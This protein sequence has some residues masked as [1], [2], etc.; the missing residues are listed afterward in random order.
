MLP[1]GTF[2]KDFYKKMKNLHFQ[3]SMATSQE[4]PRAFGKLPFLIY[5]L[6]PHF[7]IWWKLESV[8]K[9]TGIILSTQINWQ[10]SRY[11]WGFNGNKNF[12]GQSSNYF[13]IQ[14]SRLTSKATVNDAKY[15][16]KVKVKVIIK[17][18]IKLKLKLK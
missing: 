18:N 10:N 9:V 16:V 4:N 1:S 14:E 11:I 2:F 8:I 3:L 13:Y 6:L 12:V 17:V 7:R 5:G 15:K